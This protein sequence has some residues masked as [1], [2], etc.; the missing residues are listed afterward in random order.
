MA[1]FDD[2]Q[3]L[4]DAD[5]VSR[6]SIPSATDPGPRA[7]EERIMMSDTGAGGIASRARMLTAAAAAVVAIATGGIVLAT[8]GPAAVTPD[9]TI[10]GGG[11]LAMCAFLYDLETLAE[12]DFAFDGTV[13]SVDGDKATYTVNEW[14]K[15]GSGA[16]ITLDGASGLGSLASTGGDVV[17]EPGAHVLV[18]GDDTF[19]WSCGFTQAYDADIADAWR[20][21]LS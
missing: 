12:R 10:G 20:T 19:A 8:R 7:L 3:R 5:P 18:A 14:F 21:A 11:G 17:L 15:G 16:E 2:L 6:D 13:A 1:E 9:E 4:R